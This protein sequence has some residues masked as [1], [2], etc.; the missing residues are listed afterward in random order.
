MTDAHPTAVVVL[1]AGEGTRMQLG[2]P[3]GAA[4]DGRA[5]AA[6]PRARRGRPAGRRHHAGR[7]RRTAGTRS[8]PTSPRSRRTRCRVVQDRAARHRARRPGRAARPRRTSTGTVAACCPATPRCCAPRRCAGW[9][10]STRA[11]APSRPCS[12][13]S[14]PDPT[15]YGRVLRG[16]DGAV[17]RDRRAQ[18]ADRRAAGRR[19]DQHR[20]CTRSRPAPLRGRAGP[21]VHRQRPGRGVPDRRRRPVRRG[22][23]HRRRAA[24]PT[25]SRPPGVNDRVQLAGRAP[26]ATT[27]GC[28]SAWMRA[29]V[30]VLD[31][32]TTW[33]DA[34]VELGAG[35]RRCG[36]ACSCTARTTVARRRR[37]RPGLHADRH[38]RRRA[39]RSVVRAHCRPARRS[40]RTP[41]VGPFAYLRPGTPARP[42]HQGRHATSRSRTAEIGAG[43]KVPHLSYVG[44]A[45]IGAGTNIGAGTI[46]ANYDGVAKHRTDDRRP[47]PDRQRHRCWSRRSPSATAPTPRPAR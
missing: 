5:H 29:G 14:L 44:D 10:R 30:T 17:A 39:A 19:R 43:A 41:T 1:A 26:G 4:R 6:R 46:F 18:D 47:R 24:S 8:P 21:A 42:R 36:P 22:R 45:T 3:Q 34:D 35:R 33:I 28:S 40:A 37:G 32:A 15:G 38:R 27:T 20:A 7:G 23:A 31:P 12:P 11:A 25:R 9:S 2:P 16:A 13:P